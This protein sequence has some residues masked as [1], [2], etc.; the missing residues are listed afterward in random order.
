MLLKSAAAEHKLIMMISMIS[1]KN[2]CHKLYV[3]INVGFICKYKDYG[4]GVYFKH[5][6]QK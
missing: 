4:P 3:H 2:W 5:I 6:A 1:N